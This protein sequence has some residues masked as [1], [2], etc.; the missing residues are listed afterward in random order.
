AYRPAWQLFWARLNKGLASDAADIVA[1][2]ARRFPDSQYPAQ[3]YQQLSQNLRQRGRRKEIDKLVERLAREHPADASYAVARARRLARESKFRD[4]AKLLRETLAKAEERRAAI[5]K[6]VPPEVGPAPKADDFADKK[7]H[8]KAHSEWHGKQ[9]THERWRARL[10]AA[11]RAPGVL[12]FWL[13]RVSSQDEE[14]RARFMKEA[15]EKAKSEAPV[16]REWTEGTLACLEASGDEAAFL[17]RLEK[18]VRDEPRDPLWPYRLGYAY[19]RAGK[20]DKGRAALAKLLD[21][22]PEDAD[23]AMTLHAVSLRLRDAAAAERYRARAFEALRKRPNDLQNLAYGWGQRRPE[24]ALEAWRALAELDQWRRNGYAACQAA[25]IAQRL[26]RTDEAVELYFRTLAAPDCSNGQSAVQQLAAMAKEETILVKVER[27][28]KEAL[29]GEGTATRALYLKLLAY[30]LKKI[31]GRVEE[32]GSEL[33]AAVKLDISTG[34]YYHAGQALVNAL[35]DEKRFDDAEQYALTGGGRLTRD[36][37]RQLVRNA[38]SRLRDKNNWQPAARLYRKL[39]EDPDHNSPNDRQNLVRTFVRGKRLKEAEAELRRMEVGQHSWSVQYAWQEV[40]RALTNRDDHEKAVTL[41]LE[42]WEKLRG[43]TRSYGNNMLYTLMEACRQALARP[44][45]LSTEVKEKAKKAILDAA[46]EHFSGGTGYSSVESYRRECVEKLGLADAV[47]ALA[48][49]AAESDDPARVMR[50]A[51]YSQ[52]LRTYAQA[53]ERYERALDLGGDRRQI[54]Q[55]M[56]RLCVDHR[57][58]DW[59]SALEYLE[60]LKDLGT[61]DEPRY[62]QERV[63]CLY[64]LGRRDEAR[65][66]LRKALRL[67]RRSRDHWSLNSLAHHAERAKDHEMAA[68][69][70]EKVIRTFRATG[71]VR[72]RTYYVWQYYSSLA[73]AY[74]GMGRTDD[75][76]DAYLRGMSLIKRGDSHYGSFL[77]SL[78]DHVFGKQGIDAAVKKYEEGL[79]ESGGAEMPHLRVAFGEA[80]KKARRTKEALAQFRIAADLLPKDVPLRSEVIDG[81]RKLGE[82]DAAIDAYF[83]WARL[84]PQ[85]IEIYK[86]LG[87]LYASLDRGSDALAAWQTCAEVRPR[88][89]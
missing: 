11:R 47:G 74:S 24:W 89:A 4:A 43:G 9:Q 22:D 51:R 50:A 18:L 56:Y 72:S 69:V 29:E 38:A 39:L 34:G 54:L 84:D 66:E 65:E 23:L 2:L 87:D 15:A 60:P 55:G 68:E 46:R 37:R 5:E 52:K 86:G 33:S 80:Y 35:V 53:R 81:Y 75:A 78:R 14:L 7:D 40:T 12:I 88:E 6:E 42:G 8:G 25:Q 17:K 85:N 58:K 77:R 57:V 30:R 73:R 27:R 41:A 13:G 28:L 20:L 64:G 1:E 79:E 76:V 67:P 10:E 48:Q 71:Q 49:G 19:L 63:R 21:A 3:M 83:S 16:D 31:R 70:W 82:S 26:E 61:Y 32:A 59:G 44:G 62:L 36:S 45:R